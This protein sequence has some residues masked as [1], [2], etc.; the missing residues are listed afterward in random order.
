MVSTE[1][2][3]E[4]QTISEALKWVTSL[5]FEIG[6]K[7]WIAKSIEE[8]Q[9]IYL[10]LIEDRPHLDVDIDGLVIKVAATL[11]ALRSQKPSSILFHAVRWI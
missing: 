4:K 8:I 5:G 7:Q 3:D 9:Q 1:R 10:K 11:V 6:E 2:F